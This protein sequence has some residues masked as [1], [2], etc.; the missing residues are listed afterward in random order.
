LSSRSILNTIISVSKTSSPGPAPAFTAVHVSR[1]ILYIGDQGPIGRIEL[2]RKLG[3]GEGA[4]RTIV[5]HLTK[6]KLVDIAKG[7]CVLTQRGTTFYESLRSKLS[8]VRLVNAR[9]LALD[10]ASAAVLVRGSSKLVNRGIEQRD[11]AIRVGATGACT[12]IYKNGKLV[13]P[14]NERE[15]WNLQPHGSLFAELRKAFSPSNDD[16]ITIV[17]APSQELA[18][19]SAMAAALTLLG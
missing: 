16:V 4:V 10:K 9:E 6:A 14:M 2:S 12:L 17:S 7:G 19:H 3:V 15:N 5:R 18:E 8:E 1:A 11:A 13:M